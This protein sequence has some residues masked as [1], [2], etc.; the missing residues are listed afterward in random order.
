MSVQ[1]R[2]S[3]PHISGPRFLQTGDLAAV[4][5]ADVVL[6]VRPPSLLSSAV[7]GGSEV[8]LLQPNSRLISY[9]QPAQHKQLLEKLVERRVTAFAMD[10][11]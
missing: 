11:V 3:T 1:D 2:T 7:P 6:K 8:G 5:G 4:Y 10:Q 9:I